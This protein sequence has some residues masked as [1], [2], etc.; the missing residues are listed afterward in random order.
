MQT[1]DGKESDITSLKKL[2]KHMLRQLKKGKYINSDQERKG[3]YDREFKLL[4]LLIT[5]DLITQDEID[6]LLTAFLKAQDQ[7]NGKETDFMSLKKC[8]RG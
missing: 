2:L 7:L 5:K 8:Y 4:A 6:R 3:Q 1:L